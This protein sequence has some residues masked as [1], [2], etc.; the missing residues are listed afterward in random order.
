[1][2][3]SG[4]GVSM[5]GDVGPG[6]DA[7]PAVDPVERERETLLGQVHAALDGVMVGLS[8]AWI[9]LLVA[10]IV[11]GGLPR[12]L[13]VAVWAIWGIF[14]LD[15]ALEFT[16]APNKRR[17]LR[18]HWLTAVSLVLP[19]FRILRLAAV[20]RVLRGARVVRSVGLLRVLTSVNRG[21]ASLRATAARRTTSWCSTPPRSP[22]TATR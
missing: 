9:A 1:M 4:E 5:T 16:I 22:A 18:S 15:F 7:P 8:V 17:Y 3:A 21:L 12:S 19:A 6:R 2:S 14:I 20:L 11:G 13:E 10:E